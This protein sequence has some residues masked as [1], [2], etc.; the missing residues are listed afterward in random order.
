MEKIKPILQAFGIV[1]LMLIVPYCLV[2]AFCII[3]NLP[4]PYADTFSVRHGFAM[5]LIAFFSILAMA[6]IEENNK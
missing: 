2:L 3:T 5:F 4:L 6:Y 1:A